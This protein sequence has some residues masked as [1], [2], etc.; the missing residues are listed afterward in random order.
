MDIYEKL[1][2]L[3][4]SAKYDA[5]CASSGGVKGHARPGV[6][7]TNLP[8][9]CC[10]SFAAD[11]RCISLLKV[12]FSNACVYDCKYCVNRRSNDFRR[13][14]FEPK[15]LAALLVEFYR[16]NY[17][18]GLFLSSA[19]IKDPNYTTERMIEC[20]RIIREDYGFRGYIHAKSIPGADDILTQRLGLLVDRMSVNIEL[21]SEESLKLL[22]PSKEKK[23]I[24]EPMAYIR[25]GIKEH[26]EDMVKYAHTPLFVPAGQS[27]Q[28]I[29]GAT[30]ETDYKILMLSQGLYRKYGL[31][32]V[33]YSAYMPL[34]ED[35]LLP[36]IDTKPPLLR[37]HRL[38][39]ADWLMRYYEFTADEIIDEKHP[40]LNPMLDPKCNWA[41]NHPE[42]FPVEVNTA[43]YEMLLRV[44][45]VG[46]Q[47]AK[48]IVKARRSHSLDFD[49]L[50]RIGVVMKRARF[51]L[52][53]N[54][55]TMQEM[56]K[57]QEDVVLYLLNPAM[58][59]LTASYGNVKQ[60]S[61]FEVL[62][63]REDEISCLTG[64]L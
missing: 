36:S 46:V 9:G 59:K 4:E 11:G 19:V 62:P 52:T 43:D 13:A 3:A 42:F 5:S 51:F 17:V 35:S 7:G 15:E 8:A 22:A 14:T 50:I 1:E 23:A 40:L 49:G 54:G 20:I 34:Q 24:L 53:C 6:I 30:P 63:T 12:L 45:G 48:R 29:V 57:N 64:E 37:E 56:P 2:I 38:Y 33:Y 18:E 28:M 39:Q 25:D 10:H 55:H 60:M 26:R 47:S 44:P 31:K 61:F 41:I 21:P 16:R 27:T 58:E 32:R